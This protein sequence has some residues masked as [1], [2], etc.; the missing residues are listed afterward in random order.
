MAAR[1]SKKAAVADKPR[2]WS[3]SPRLQW[4]SRIVGRGV[5]PA[6]QLLANPDN[7]RIHT[8]EQ[9]DALVGVL[10]RVGWVRGV[11]VNRRTGHVVDGH[12][13]VKAALAKG[14]KTPVPYEEIDVTE[15][16]EALLLASLDPLSAMAGT[17]KAKRDELLGLLPEDFAELARALHADGQATRQVTF[18]AAAHHHRVIV[19]CGDV[20]SQ[21]ALL[22]RLREEG[23]TCRAD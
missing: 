18:E 3:N 23:Y 20:G 22:R 1:K 16:E 13:R 19:E 15:H 12:L 5:M 17:D 6:A 9:E 10:D 8:F 14:D 2:R 11:L 4:R 21:D 7:W